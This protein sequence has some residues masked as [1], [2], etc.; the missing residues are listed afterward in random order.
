VW[1]E[2]LETCCGRRVSTLKLKND[3]MKEI[4]KDVMGY[5]GIYQV[6]DLGNTR[7]LNMTLTEISSECGPRCVRLNGKVSI[8]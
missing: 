5:E 3:N 7:S 6:S 1:A 4:W 8:K 2:E